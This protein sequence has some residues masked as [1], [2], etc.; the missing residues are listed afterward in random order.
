MRYVPPPLLAQ[1]AAD[2]D[3]AVAR[4]S[5]ASGRTYLDFYRKGLELTGAA[6]RA[7]VRVLLG[8]D[9]GDSFVFPGSG[10]HDE[11]GELVAAGLSPAEALRAGTLSGAEFLGLSDR[12]G[13][14]EVGKR[15]DLVLLTANPLDD[16]SNVR[17]IRAV[18]LGGEGSG[19]GPARRVADASRTDRSATD[20]VA[21]RRQSSNRLLD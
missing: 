4:D 20:A 7:G 9:G 18:V 12:Y 10:A 19:P 16:I 2:A 5:A 17:E 1:W 15:A 13:S 21:V 3:R 11:L 6:H 14:V 8:T